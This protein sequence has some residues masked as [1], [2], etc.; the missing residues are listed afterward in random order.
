MDAIVNCAAYCEGRRVANVDLDEISNMLHQTDKFVWIGLHEPD[1]ALLHKVQKQFRLHDLA[2][3]DAH[4]AHQ[5]P[6]LESYGDTL[7]IVLRT[8]QMNYKEHHIDF[9]ETHFFL[10]KNFI[11]TVSF[12]LLF[13]ITFGQS[14]K[15]S[16]L[17]VIANEVC[18]EI[19]SDSASF[20]NKD[21]LTTNLGLAM[22]PSF[23]KHQAELK[24]FF[25][26]DMMNESGM[27]EFGKEVGMKLV[28]NCP[29]FLKMFKENRTAFMD[30]ATATTGKKDALTTFSGTLIKIVP[31]DFTYFIVKTSNGKLEKIWWQEY[32]KGSEKINASNLNKTIKVTFVEKDIYNS[33]LKDYIKQKI[34]TS[35]E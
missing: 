33:T 15:D 12:F 26:A 10:G 6:K 7:F 8:A 31:G 32:F 20:K 14:K 29:Q 18:V 16:L 24:E 2:V 22:M 3:E 27:E 35:V 11:V 30:V 9:G 13:S 34:A 17:V 28:T 23:S 25:N 5:R 21:D 1:E 4:N 19:T